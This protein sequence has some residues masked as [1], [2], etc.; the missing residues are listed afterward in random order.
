MVTQEERVQPSQINGQLTSAQGVVEQ[1]VGSV[2]PEALGSASW[3]E[4]GAELQKQG[5]KEVEEAKAQKAL[6][7]TMDSGVA[8]AKTAFG[9]LTS[10]QE[11]QDQGNQ[12]SQKAQ[13]DY[14]QATSDKPFD[15][16]VP[17]VE[18]MKGRLE[19]VEGMIKGDQEK[20]MEGNLRVEKAAWKDG[21]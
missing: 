16:P 1:A 8:K 2:L 9:Y 17:S 14:K 7:A 18:G 15:I 20:Q 5:Q 19:T 12:E 10:D 21:V 13:A 3:L 4:S 11:T 6:G